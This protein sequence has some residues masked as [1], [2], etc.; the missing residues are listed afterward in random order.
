MDSWMTWLISALVKVVLWAVFCALLGSVL[1]YLREL[2][3]PHT[4]GSFLAWAGILAGIPFALGC[5]TV[6]AVK[7]W[8]EMNGGLSSI[9]GG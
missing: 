3:Q 6:N 2:R 4:P 5:I 1:A 8:L 7:F 9:I